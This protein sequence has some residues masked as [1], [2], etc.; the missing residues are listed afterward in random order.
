MKKRG[1]ILAL[2]MLVIFLGTNVKAKAASSTD[3]VQGLLEKL[4]NVIS[5]EQYSNANPYTSF[6]AVY[7]VTF[8]MPLDWEH[9]EV[10]TFPQRVFVNYRGQERD[11]TYKAG[12][13]ALQDVSWG[14]PGNEYYISYA[15]SCEISDAY[16]SNLV[17][18][19]HR[20]FGLSVPE[21]LDPDKADYWEYLTVE[22]AA[23][24]FHYIISELSK[25]LYGT[26]VFT[27]VSKGG[28]ITNVQAMLFPEDADVFVA[29]VA[30]FDSEGPYGSAYD[31]VFNQIGDAKYGL[32]KAAELRGIVKNLILEMYRYKPEILDAMD[33][34]Y[35]QCNFNHVYADGKDIT[36]EGVFDM[37][38]LDYAFS[39]WQYQDE[40][41]F[42]E[43]R[44]S[45]QNLE[46]S[47]R[48]HYYAKLIQDSGLYESF[49]KG[50][51]YYP[52]YYQALCEMGYPNYIYNYV[53]EFIDEKKKEDP[54]Y[55]RDGIGV[56][57]PEEMDD[58][59]FYDIMISDALK[60]IVKENNQIREQLREY[61]KTNQV[62]V[63]QIDGLSDPW[64]ALGF[65]RG[66]NPN[67]HSYYAPGNHNSEIFDLTV[68]EQLEI[69][70]IVDAALQYVYKE[71]YASPVQV[72]GIFGED[73]SGAVTRLLLANPSGD[74]LAVDTKEYHFLTDA[75]L[76]SW[77]NR[78]DIEKEIT[79]EDNGKEYIL[80]IPADCD[81]SALL[82][83]DVS[84][85]GYFTFAQLVPGVQIK[86]I[87]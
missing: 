60:P 44:S 36:R 43:I 8:E 65:P 55:F 27:G 5:V 51:R 58:T 1:W 73:L 26:S 83:D 3:E 67:I 68:D 12:G 29:Y 11:T 78:S 85:Y 2:C 61:L 42:Y 64:S 31:Y 34:I 38:V 76:E 15:L 54:T 25:V 41:D 21:G 23:K 22:N 28:Y 52:Y 86:K 70:G 13:Y 79:F 39:L 53:R 19:E 59:F 80:L 30:P 77:S 56:S 49:D 10:G 62:P 71:D 9:P 16:Q 47:D 46:E 4:D 35:E 57:V 72:E 74:V 17:N 7:V 84:C 81:Y 63:I 75:I 69:W 66:D 45:I 18:I 32:E 87:M 40:E 50:S 82:A 14:D 37:A 6:E 24:D 20:Y 33:E 48:I